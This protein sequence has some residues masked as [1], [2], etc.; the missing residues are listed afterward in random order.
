MTTET[1]KPAEGAEPPKSLKKE[2]DLQPLIDA[3]APRMGELI[4]RFF[5]TIRVG[6]KYNLTLELGVVIVAVAVLGIVGM[7]AWYAVQ[8]GNFEVAERIAIPLISFVGGF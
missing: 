2:V 3:V 7:V 8:A 6:A 1:P 4:D 5:G